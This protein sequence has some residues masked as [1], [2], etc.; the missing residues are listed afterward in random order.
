[1]KTLIPV[2][3]LLAVG[4]AQATPIAMEDQ[5]QLK[6]P[7]VQ[8]APQFVPPAERELPD[9]AF[10]KMVREGHALFVD[11]RRLMPEAVG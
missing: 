9:N 10:G 8:A 4:S 3:L 7:G 5:S 11:T 1:M 2:L 6:V